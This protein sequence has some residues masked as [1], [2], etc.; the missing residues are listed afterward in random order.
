M[1]RCELGMDRDNGDR[2]AIGRN[3]RKQA[4]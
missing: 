3:N 1:L 4:L 2:V